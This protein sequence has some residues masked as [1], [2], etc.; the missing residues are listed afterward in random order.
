MKVDPRGSRFRNACSLLLGAVMTCA[1]GCAGEADPDGTAE[2][3]MRDAAAPA[4]GDAS[5]AADADAGESPGTAIAVCSGCP[6]DARDPSDGQIRV[7]HIHLNV[8]DADEA[9]AFYSRF[10]GARRVR[11]NGVADA[12]W[13][14]PLLFLL[15]Q[16]DFDFDGDLRVGFEHV[17]MGVPD[18]A[19]WFEMASADGVVVDP[20]NGA[21]AMPLSFPFTPGSSPFLDPEVDTFAFVYVLGPNGERVEVWSGLSG[22]RHAHFMTPDIDATVAWYQALLGVDPL[23]PMATGAAGLVSN[24]IALDGVQLNF[25]APAMP[26]DFIETDGQPIDHIAFSVPDLDALFAHVQELGVEIVSEPAQT[27]LGFR[28]FFVRAPQRA[29]LEF[30]AAG[31]VTVP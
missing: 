13:A 7:H 1:A 18:P 10:F 11:L 16:G 31:K 29:L 27:A 22:F 6:G 23:L 24:G 25:L 3:A 28:S 4:A 5:A 17:G 30:V 20:R 14:E 9:I 21:P 26:L 8:R 12:L 15:E 19:A 2:H